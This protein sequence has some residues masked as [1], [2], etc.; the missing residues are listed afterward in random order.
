MVWDEDAPFC[1][2][3]F[4]DPEILWDS[5]DPEFTPC[6]EKT[7]LVWG[8]CLFLWIFSPLEVF[9]ISQ[10]RC[11]DIPWG[12]LNT[13]KLFMNLV[14]FGL[15]SASL[16][17]S[18]AVYFSGG[19]V[20]PVDIWTPVVQMATFVLA[21]V[22]LLWNKI[23]GIQTSG[24]LF[25]F[26]LLLSIGGI[27]QF[28]TEIRREIKGELGDNMFGFIIYMIYY[29]IVVLMFLFNFF[30]DKRP[31]ETNYPRSNKK[32]CPEIES[33][34]VSKL[35]FRWL[36]PLVWKGYRRPLTIEDL[37]D[38][39]HQDKSSQITPQFQKCWDKQSQNKT[40]PAENG[41]SKTYGTMAR[42]RIKKQVN[43]L[44]PI[45]RTFWRLFAAGGTCRVVG[46]LFS[47]ASPQILSL[48]MKFVAS[49][50]YLW[51]GVVYA[52]GLFLASEMQT[53]FYHHN[54]MT[55]S[56]LGLNIRTAVISAI[57]RK[58]LRIS[59]AARRESP[60]GEVVNLMAVD[61]QRFIDFS[62]YFNLIYA[63]PIIIIIAMYFLWD[64]LG[65]SAFAGLAIMVILVPINIAIANRVKSFQMKQ[66]KYKD[67]RV[68]LM[69]E[70]LS[71]VK[72]LKLYAWEPSFEQQICKI[73][74]KEVSMLRKAALLNASISF[75][76]SCSPFLV[77]LAT[78]GVYVMSDD[79]HV[80][81]AE[82][83]FV[84]ASLF[85]LMKNPINMFPQAV[86]VLVQTLVSTKR[87]NKFLNAEEL[88]VH[89]VSHDINEREPLIMD[90][91]T[92]SWGTESSDQPI[93]R[94]IDLRVKKGSLVA[95]VGAVG[96]G[97][98][99]LINAFLG[100]MDK[101]SGYINTTGRIAYVPQQ[102]WIQNA[103][104][105]DNILFGLRHDSKRYRNTIESCAL[106]QDLE[107]LPG[108]DATEIGEK[109][110]NLSGGQKQRVSLAR[111]V[112]NDAD[113]YL[114]DDPLSA[115]DSHV[116]KHI[117]ENVIGPKG[118]LSKKTRLLVT[119]GVTFLPKVDVIVVLKDGMISEIGTFKELLNERGEFA[120]FLVQHITETEDSE[121]ESE[122][123]EMVEENPLLRAKLQKQT[124]SVESV[125]SVR[126][127]ASSGRRKSRLSSVNSDRRESIKSP[128]PANQLIQIEKAETGSVK[129]GVYGSYIRS[130]GTLLA[131]GFMLCMVLFQ[132]FSVGANAW[133]SV[134][135][136]DNAA[137]VNGVQD[138][139]KR[140][141]YL[142]I[143]MSFGLGQ[144]LSTWASAF[145]L[146]FGSVLASKYLHLSMLA[147][148]L[149]APM[150]FFDTTPLGRIVNRFSKDIDIVDNTLPGNLNSSI[151][152]FVSVAGTLVVIIYSTP[153]YI[154][155]IIP[156]GILYILI[157]RF[158][159][160]ASRQLKRIESVTRSPIYSHFSETVSGASSVRAYG[161]ENRFI[162]TS[163]DR[164][165]LNQ[166]CLYPSMVSNRWLGVRLETVG[167]LM[168]FFAALFAVIG[169]DTLNAGIVGLSI[170]YALQITGVLN[171]AVR[172]ASEVETNIVSVERISEYSQ[173]PQEA[174]W[175]LQFR[176]PTE[177]PINGAIN[178]QNYQ[179]R[180]REGL[181]LV[182]RGITLSVNG[183]EKV[184]IVGRTGAGKS[185]LTL[186]LFR[187]LEAA[188]G[189]IAIDGINIAEMG[190]GDLRSK[191]TI[192]PQDPV[193][194]S[195]SLRMNLDPFEKYSDSDIWR[196]LE[197]AHLNDFARGLAAGLNHTI[198]EGGDN[199]SVGQRQLI[200]LARALLRKTKV[201]ILDEATAA[202]DLE[203]DDIIQQTIRREFKDCTV[204]T[205][206]HRLNTIMDSDRVLVLD[207]GMIKEFDSPTN[208]LRS[209]STTFYGMAKDAGLV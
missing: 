108:G 30:P 137:V 97:K 204:L 5:P 149:R 14:L 32:L 189:H 35:I 194:F 72:V 17:K 140:D 9:F 134:W 203:T 99:S 126:S 54:L 42:T 20:F 12:I 81:T 125:R 205:I 91:A 19:Q 61:A 63:A 74:E 52:I 79:S 75:L 198:T 174:A 121:L 85:N 163:E 1:N 115:V 28:R 7:V 84:A 187:I 176:P 209:D 3:T 172:Q 179:V 40:H 71:G 16:F 144:L 90:S 188:G 123:E 104:V 135:T 116:G 208:L 50:E 87:I 206:A 114:L 117:F 13:C 107:M 6:F 21:I 177:W 106:A 199:V 202:I 10:S 138:T 164:V 38:L 153:I 103:T 133:L 180:Y 43:V 143:Y 148:V 146:A 119:H 152:C 70:V 68:K 55:M 131:L 62:A 76:W 80:L 86:Q 141:Y 171:Y 56:V 192:I 113:T 170:S 185:S 45:F 101:I 156:L 196:A 151:N 127:V 96:A 184:G 167:N 159:I 112:Y 44:R 33:S 67:D 82:V 26:W 132:A 181:E 8:P 98:S 190:L 39:R 60:V 73:R 92:L 161:V 65:P 69:N 24:V 110:I 46:D 191:L 169:R 94:N 25:V 27:S 142:E 111:A 160:A 66:M 165:D 57:Y 120:E 37:W 88:D 102:A 122:I 150:S 22:F 18:I 47:F 29:P 23:R 186:C 58:S 200:C 173:I 166:M 162:R 83:A 197:H 78:F 175:Q 128:E 145:L 154:F 195:G 129:I 139:S 100:E 51:R 136:N 201:L 207:K 157:Q 59:S 118:V 130:F 147:R 77:S 53:F 4:W 31:R 178:F 2:S 182:L 11:R 48:M 158:Y 93:L 168:I 36:D 193:L 41:V 183:G 89:S 15:C 64:L 109:G 49:D 105:K 155:A 34:F 95:V 124:S